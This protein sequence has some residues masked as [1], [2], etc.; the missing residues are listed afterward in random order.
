[1]HDANDY[2]TTEGTNKVI[3]KRQKMNVL[4][5]PSQRTIRISAKFRKMKCVKYI[6]LSQ[7]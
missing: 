1:M 7:Q 6:K 4:N 3:C 2:L 5:D